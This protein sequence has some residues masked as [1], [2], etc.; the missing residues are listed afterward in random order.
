MLLPNR[1]AL[2]RAVILCG[3]RFRAARASRV[4]LEGKAVQIV[5]IQADREFAFPEFQ[6]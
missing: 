2:G 4:V 1:S 6:R 3:W 5:D